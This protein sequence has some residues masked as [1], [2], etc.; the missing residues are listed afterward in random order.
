MYYLFF[1]VKLN[2]ENIY[3]FFITFKVLCENLERIFVV[4][5]E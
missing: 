2:E 4:N 5:K 3:Y 1:Y